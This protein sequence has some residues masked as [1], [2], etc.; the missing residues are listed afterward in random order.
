[1]KRA[2]GDH[3][4]H[5]QIFRLITMKNKRTCQYWNKRMKRVIIIIKSKLT[6][7]NAIIDVAVLNYGDVAEHDFFD[8]VIQSI[9]VDSSW[10]NAG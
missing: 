6:E 8:A 1:M 2:T 7:V 5:S 3:S 10:L 9:Q 4:R